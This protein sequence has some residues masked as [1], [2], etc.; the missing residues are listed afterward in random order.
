MLSLSQAPA[1][2]WARAIVRNLVSQVLDLSR[3]TALLGLPYQ[4][5]PGNLSGS[6]RKPSVNG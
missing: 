5:G 6:R 2:R 3:K 4:S 1:E